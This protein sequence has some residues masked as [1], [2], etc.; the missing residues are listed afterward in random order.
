[1]GPVRFYVANGLGDHLDDPSEEAMRRFLDAIDTS[2]EE[3]GAAWLSTDADYTL[4]WSDAVLVV[5]GPG[6][7]PPSRHMRKVPRERALELWIALA[8]GDVAAVERCGWRLGNG[9]APDPARDERLRAWQL[10]QDRKFYDLLG[11]ERS[12]VPCRGDG[13]RRGAVK[14]SVLCRP[15]HFESVWKRPSPFSD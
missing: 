12:D 13:C 10:E 3:H 4:E 1:M 7:D 5:S 8:R 9:H 15:H 6:F 2:D 14:H 11:E